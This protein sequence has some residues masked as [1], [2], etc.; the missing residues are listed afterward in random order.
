MCEKKYC[1]ISDIKEYKIS[2]DVMENIMMTLDYIG[3]E[4]PHYF[5]AGKLSYILQQEIIKAHNG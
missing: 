3:T 1:L 5:A 2:A 4:Q